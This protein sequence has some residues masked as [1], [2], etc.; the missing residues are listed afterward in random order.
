MH[1][2]GLL[3]NL[4]ESLG[5]SAL[6][7]RRGLL[8]CAYRLAILLIIRNIDESRG[9]ISLINDESL[10]ATINEM[11]N[12]EQLFQYVYIIIEYYLFLTH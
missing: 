11:K 8:K 6:P 10:N 5:I 12:D 3:L 7:S 2:T 9:T 1:S 4:I